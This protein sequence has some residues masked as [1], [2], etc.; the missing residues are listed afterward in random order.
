MTMDDYLRGYNGFR[1]SERDGSGKELVQYRGQEVKGR[2]GFNVRLTVD[3]G[4]QNIVEN[5]LQAA[6]EQYHPKMALAI[7]MR[8]QTGEILALANRPN[9]DPALVQEAS[10]E[11]LKNVSILNIMEPGSTF[12]IVTTAAALNEKKVSLDST[13]FCENGHFSYAGKVLHDHHGY[14]DLT[15]ADILVKSSN[16]GVAKLALQLGDTKFYEY[17]RSFGFGECTGVALPG[18]IRG[19]VHPV[20]SWSKI[21]ITRMPMGQGVGVT[22]MQTVAAMAAIANGGSLMMPQIVK[23]IVDED[24]QVVK[25]FAPVKV[26]QPVS[27]EVTKQITSALKDVCSA[28]GTA[29]GAKV[30]GFSVAGKTGTANMANPKGGYFEHKYVVSFVGFMP[31]DDPAFVAIVVLQEPVTKAD[32]YYGGLV[33]APVFAKIGEKAARY[34]NLQPEPETP[35]D[36]MVLTKS[37]PIN[38]GLSGK[39][40]ED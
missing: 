21:S 11:A 36:N 40:E 35:A 37:G 5:E 31:A 18:E 28:R 27:T 29:V 24:G 8:P 30:P 38:K 6:C 19:I 23:E 3:M 13:I 32:A 25:S 26:R 17:I 39:I 1:F 9:F 12:K 14:G 4:L 15:V 22:A 20:Q 10:P 16:I 34:L 7:L 33:C 2:N